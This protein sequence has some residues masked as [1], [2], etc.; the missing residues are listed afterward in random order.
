MNF[1]VIGGGPTGVE[2]AGAI[3]ELAKRIGCRILV[4]RFTLCTDRSGRGGPVAAGTFR[5]VYRISQPAEWRSELV[6]ELRQLPA[7]RAPD[8]RD[9]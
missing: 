6:L 5:S 2:M 8:H 4:H 1:I 3:A 9:S 7:R